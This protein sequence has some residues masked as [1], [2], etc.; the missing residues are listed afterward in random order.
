MGEPDRFNKSEAPASAA[1]ADGGTGTHMS[2]QT[3]TWN[4]SPRT[5]SASKRRSGPKGTVS[6]GTPYKARLSDAAKSPPTSSAASVASMTVTPGRA[7]LSPAHSSPDA[8]CRFS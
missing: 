7:I 2:S 6:G 5:S 1:R 4:V 3:S 8:K